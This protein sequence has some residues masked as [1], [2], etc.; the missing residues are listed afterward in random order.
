MMASEDGSVYIWNRWSDPIPIINVRITS[1]VIKNNRVKSYES[2][3]PF[4][5][6]K[7]IATTAVF[8]PNETLKI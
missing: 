1:N 4:D 2:F 3:M 6:I 7:A 8:A 5:D